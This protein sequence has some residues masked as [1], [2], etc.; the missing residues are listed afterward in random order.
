MEI[1]VANIPYAST[2][3]DICRLFDDFGAVERVNIVT[4]Q[5]T[6]RS[7]GFGFVTMPNEDEARAAVDAL[8]GI[9]LQGRA[10][11]INKARPRRP[12]SSRRD[13]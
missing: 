13:G 9:E 1:F 6:G 2:Q 10:L 11:A 12:R 3:E 8:N 4:D 5:E 7:R